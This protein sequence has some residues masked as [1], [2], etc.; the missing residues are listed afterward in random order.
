MTT[1]KKKSDAVKFLEN[2]S[3]GPLSLGEFMESI[4][5]GED[6]SQTKFAEKLELSKSHLCDIEKGRKPVS[7]ARAAEFAKTLGYS[8][9]QFVRLALQDELNRSGLKFKI[10]IESAS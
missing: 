3:G 1:K 2:L 10:N 9:E 8:P 7:A 5:L 4:R 6:L